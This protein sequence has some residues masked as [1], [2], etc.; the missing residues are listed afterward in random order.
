MGSSTAKSMKELS[1]AYGVG[2]RA[3][4]ITPQIEDEIMFRQRFSLPDASQSVKEAW[5]EDGN[6]RRPI[7]LKAGDAF[8]A[9]QNASV[10]ESDGD[11][12]ETD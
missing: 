10:N 12:D 5:A 9:E 8:N 4:A 7:T 11:S 1:D 6:V 3:G 2:V